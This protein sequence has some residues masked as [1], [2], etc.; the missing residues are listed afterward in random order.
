MCICSLKIGVYCKWKRGQSQAFMS[1]IQWGEL[2]WRND[3]SLYLKMTRR[4]NEQFNCSLTVKVTRQVMI[5]TKQSHQDE[6]IKV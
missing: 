5:L 1:S 2:Q 6:F 4:P 3:S